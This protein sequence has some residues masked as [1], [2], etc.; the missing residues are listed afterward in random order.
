MAITTFLAGR[1]KVLHLILIV[2]VLFSV[3]PI[4]FVGWQLIAINTETLQSKEKNYQ[5]QS[6][7][8]KAR[9]I[10][11]YVQGYVAQVNSYARAFEITGN[12]AQAA[13]PAGQES[14]ARQTPRRLQII[15]IR[16]FLVMDLTNLLH[17]LT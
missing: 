17:K 13:S 8:N 1:I 14:L 2:L 4:A 11:L 12:L 15:C 9:Q 5:V 3:A 10:E 6:V 16:I 7:R